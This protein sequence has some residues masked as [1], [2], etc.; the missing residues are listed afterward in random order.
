M[1]HRTHAAR[2]LGG[3]AAAAAMLL[4]SPAAPRSTTA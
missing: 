1:P 3:I 2:L 4:G